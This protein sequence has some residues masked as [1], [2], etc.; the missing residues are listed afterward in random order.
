[1]S[2]NKNIAISDSGFLFNPSSGESFSV[3]QTGTE[4][5]N[6]IKE[7]KSDNEICEYFLSKYDTN[8][9]TFDKDLQDFKEMI[10]QYQLTDN[11]KA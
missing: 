3:N 4:I 1:M 6:M 7:G 8:A 11:D 10:S 9:N 2:I 5:L